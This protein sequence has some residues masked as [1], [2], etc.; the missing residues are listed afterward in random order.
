M[1][2]EPKSLTDLIKKMQENDNVEF[3]EKEDTKVF[4]YIGYYHGYKGYRFNGSSKEKFKFNNFK[5]IQ[6]LYDFDSQL[7]ALFY[8]YI[9]F[10]E[11]TIKNYALAIIVLECGSSR[12]ADIYANQ[13]TRHKH[14]RANSENY[15]N[16]FKSKL[17]VRN[18][19][20]KQISR[21]Y[22]KN[23]IVDYYYNEKDAPVPL[24][25]IFELISLGEFGEFLKCLNQKTLLK[26]SE[27]IGLPPELRKNLPTLVFYLKDLRNA[28]AHNNIIFDG[29]FR[30][31]RKIS[32][33]IKDELNGFLNSSQSNPADITYTIDF[34]TI[35]DYMVFIVILLKGLRFSKDQ[36]LKIIQKYTAL[37]DEL[38]ENVM[39]EIYFS[40]LHTDHRKQ[41]EK[42]TDF[43]CKMS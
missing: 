39:P 41:L 19:V 13:L 16:K 6:A 25:A 12:F 5:Q 35:F 27:E 14:F 1:L 17:N 9:M 8:P 22:D 20:Y 43:I 2:R 37:T 11:T 36:L 3:D 30:Y 23:S 26:I 31:N 4:K 28:I 40:I 7:K 33:D 29:R 15:K 32:K 21:S 42:F 10:L 24:W 34:T 18:I 38:H